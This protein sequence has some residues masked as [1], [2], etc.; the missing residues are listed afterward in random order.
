MVKIIQKYFEGLHGHFKYL[1]IS[2]SFVVI[3]I[4]EI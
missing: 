1:N 2:E 4:L 3:E